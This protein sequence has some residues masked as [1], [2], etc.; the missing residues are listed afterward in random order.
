MIVIDSSEKRAYSKQLENVAIFVPWLE[1]LTGA[2]M[3]ISPRELKPA[4]GNLPLHLNEGA[5]LI[6]IKRGLD[7]PASLGTR[8]N[9]SLSKMFIA[10]RQAQRVLL[11]VGFLHVDHDTGNA[12]IDGRN[13]ALGDRGKVS[14]MSVVAALTK[15]NDRGGVYCNLPTAKHFSEWVE[16]RERHLAEYKNNRTKRVWPDN[17]ILFDKPT[18]NDPLQELRPIK[19]ARITLATLP[20]IGH[21]KADDI[22]RA[23]SMNLITSL[24][25]LTD[26]TIAV[27]GI[28]KKTIENICQWVGLDED[29][30]ITLELKGK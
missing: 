19:D 6:Q 20:G 13:V 25:H 11:F 5:L 27:K 9:N 15:W 17:P 1:K 3:M 2:D 8:L 26:G 18:S 12:K 28:G 21:K 30:N 29:F 22:W 7:L 14:Y 10:P 16:Y 4:P 23:G 24:I